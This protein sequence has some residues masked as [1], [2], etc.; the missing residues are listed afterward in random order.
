MRKREGITISKRISVVLCHFQCRFGSIWYCLWYYI[1]NI[2]FCNT[3]HYNAK[4]TIDDKRTKRWTSSIQSFNFANQYALLWIPNA[5]R[6]ILMRIFTPCL[7][8]QCVFTNFQCVI[9]LLRALSVALQSVIPPAYIKNVMFKV[10]MF[11][12]L[13]QSFSCISGRFHNAVFP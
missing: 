2:C 9:T 1:A 10:S 4:E 5:Y 11:S 12:H 8:F 3:T 13:R 6:D 7:F